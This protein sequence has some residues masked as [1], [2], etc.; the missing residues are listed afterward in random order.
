MAVTFWRE[1]QAHEART[2]MAESQD[3]LCG[4]HEVVFLVQKLWGNI[5]VFQ[6]RH[7]RFTQTFEMLRSRR[8]QDEHGGKSGFS[9]WRT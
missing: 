2:S 9:V 3:S 8:S 7:V 4:V 1:R 5:R 6:C